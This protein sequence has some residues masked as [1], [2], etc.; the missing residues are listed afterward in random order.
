MNCKR[1]EKTISNYLRVCLECIRNDWKNVQPHIKEVHKSSRIKFGL[2]PTPPTQGVKCAQ[3]VNECKI[4]LNSQGYCGMFQNIDGKLVNVSQGALDW[5]FDPLPTNCVAEWV[6]PGSSAY[7]Y[8]NL[9]VF[10][11]TCSFNCLFCQNWHFRYHKP[12]VVS[13]TQLASYIDKDIFCI[14]Y[15]GGDPTPQVW[16]TI[17]VSKFAIEK[18]IKICWETNGTM[19]PQIMKKVMELSFR[20]GGCIKFDLKTWDDRLNIALCGAS[21]K[22]TIKNFASVAKWYDKRECSYP[23]LVASTL[24]IPGYV[25]LQEIRNIAHFIASLNPHIPYSLL[26]FY[27]CFLM[28]DLPVTTREQ[29]ESAFNVAKGEGLENVHLGNIHLLR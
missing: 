5:Y 21:N 17:E 8:K 16:H 28:D 19:N 25:D 11:R 15:F 22:Y 4:P 12:Q 27:P 13:P 26:A 18:G 10:Y 23:F 29:A 14:C 24:L 6:C 2:P 3:C 7:R 20:S 9:A 1:E